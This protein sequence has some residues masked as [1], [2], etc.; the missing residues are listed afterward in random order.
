MTG[1]FRSGG[2][3]KDV[4]HPVGVR[5]EDGDRPHTQT[6]DVTVV[7]A[8][9]ETNAAIPLHDAAGPKGVQYDRPGG[10]RV[11]LRPLIECSTTSCSSTRRAALPEKGLAGVVAPATRRGRPRPSDPCPAFAPASPG[12]AT[13]L[14]W[15]AAFTDGSTLIARSPALGGAQPA[16]G[17]SFARDVD[18][19]VLSESRVGESGASPCVRR[20]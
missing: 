20:A 15:T 11:G 6:N 8:S 7:V 2:C 10:R 5:H 3:L 4:L 16:K 18:A 14:T 19:G 1:P 13:R 17:R 12:R 9:A